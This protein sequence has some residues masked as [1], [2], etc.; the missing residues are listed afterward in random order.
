LISGTMEIVT[1][2]LELSDQQSFEL[3]GLV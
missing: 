1:M 2:R 3:P